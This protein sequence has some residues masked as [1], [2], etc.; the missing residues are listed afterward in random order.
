M[1][2]IAM[3][4][5]VLDV[6]VRPV[7]SIPEGQGGE[8]VDEIRITPAG[9]G[10]GTAVILAK[11]GADVRSMG[12]VGTD[13]VGDMLLSL[14]AA[15]GIDTSM[16]LRRDEAQTSASVLPIRPNGDRPAFHVVGANGTYKPDDVDLDAVAAADFLH[17]GG[18]E[19]MGGE[20][21]LPVLEHARAN[22]T[23]TSADVLAPGDPGLLEWVAP[24]FP[25]LD[26]LL[27]NDEQV[28]GFTGEDDLVAGCR[29]LVGRGVGCVAATRGADGVV[30]VD[31]SEEVLEVPAFSIE[32]VDTTGC[33]DAFSAGFLRGLSEGRDRREAAVLGCAT[34][35]LVAQGLG[36]DAGEYDLA[37]ADAFAEGAG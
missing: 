35:A 6:L 1:K 5:H 24:A 32:P 21:L 22:G 16:L 27:P 25:A 36:T 23:V 8:L 12:A 13:A 28:Q 4:V 10:G 7:E 34:A 2:A 3:G 14:L 31:S 9:T 30:I 19:F 20:A 17:V 29:A 15:H 37:A 26:Y 33:G 18:P 11:L